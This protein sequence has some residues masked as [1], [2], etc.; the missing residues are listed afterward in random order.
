[1][2]ATKTRDVKQ[3]TEAM[4]AECQVKLLIRLMEAGA[5]LAP[6]DRAPRKASECL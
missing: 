4:M 1:M 3:A 6:R 2:N 5:L